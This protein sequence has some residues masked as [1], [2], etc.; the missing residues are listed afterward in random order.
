M[1]CRQQYGRCYSAGVLLVAGAGNEYGGAVINPAA[2]DSVIAVSATDASD[3]IAAF[4][5]IGPQVEMAAPGRGVMSTVPD[6]KYDTKTGTSMSC[7]HVSGVAALVMATGVTGNTDVRS[8][9]AIT[10]LDLGDPGRDIYYGFGRVDAAAAVN[11]KK[12]RLSG[13]LWMESDMDVAYSV[14]EWDFVLFASW[15]NGVRSYNVTTGEWVDNAVS[16]WVFV[17]WPFYYIL[18]SF[19]L[20]FALPPESGLWV[21]HFS[22][23]QWAMLPRVIP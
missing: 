1:V 12:S 3:V 4:S 17:D 7:P 2:Y 18:D 8:L 20:M 15:K 14:D 11:P 23:V 6:D 5:S 16:G 22:A 19:Y 10:A 13:W 21:Y 9:L